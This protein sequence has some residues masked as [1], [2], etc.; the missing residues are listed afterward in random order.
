M[1]E[2]C[3]EDIWRLH[4]PDGRVFTH[5]TTLGTASRID[6]LYTPR[7]FRH[8]ILFSDITPCAHTDHDLISANFNFEPVDLGKGTWHLNCS[9]LLDETYK[10]HIRTL[11]SK[12]R[13]QKPK[14]SHVTLW[15]DEGKEKIKSFSRTYSM[16]KHREITGELKDRKKKLRNAQRKADLTGDACHVRLASELRNHVR[17]LEEKLAEGAKTRS[18]AIHVK[19]NETCSKYFFNLEKKHGE[20]R[21]IRAVKSSTGEILSEPT[22]IRDEIRNFYET[23]YATE[24]CDPVAQRELLNFIDK[25]VSPEQNK[26][27]IREFSREIKNAI[28]GMANGK[29]PGTDGLPAEFYKEFFDLFADDLLEVF[30]DSFT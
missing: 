24:V 25:Q 12:W 13:E 19:Q 16:K 2:L 17:R 28:L 26:A 23:L 10:N 8:S 4:H 14:F 20:D 11:W 18:K 30:Q 29:S 7:D 22:D 3:C 9:L 1:R 5:R 27:L 15:W 6:R 21:L